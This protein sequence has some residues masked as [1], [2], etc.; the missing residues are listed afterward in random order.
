MN[1]IDALDQIHL[2]REHQK[3]TYSR[4]HDQ[5]HGAHMWIALLAKQLGEA[6]EATYR[7]GDFTE[8][9]VQLAAVAVAAI[10]ARS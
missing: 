7:P 10:E 8:E 2:E 3:S 6:A 4:N 9:L 5:C 1:T